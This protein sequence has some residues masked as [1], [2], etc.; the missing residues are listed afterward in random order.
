[1]LL[2]AV[3]DLKPSFVVA[4]FDMKGPTFRYEQYADYKA[5]R[6]RAPDELYEQIPRVKALCLALGIEI[7]ELQGFEADDIIA[8]LS[9]KI[10]ANPDNEV[11]VLTGDLDTL[12]LVNDRVRVYAPQNGFNKT[13]TYDSSAVIKR[14]GLKPEQMLDFRALKGD[15]SDNIPG[16]AGIGEKTASELIATYDT[17]ENLYKHLEDIKPRTMKLLVEGKDSAKQSRELAELVYDLPVEIKDLENKFGTYDI[18]EVLELFRELGF[19]SLI[20]KL[21]RDLGSQSADKTQA[22]M[23]QKPSAT[24]HLVDNLS[25]LKVLAKK[26][27]LQKLVAIDLETRNLD[28]DILG[29][30][31]AFDSDQSFYVSTDKDGIAIGQALGILKSFLEN[32]KIKKTGH[33]IKYDYK[34]LAKAGVILEGIAFDSMLAS[35]LL[36]P[37]QNS[38][39]LDQV[40]FVELGQR[41]LD[42]LKLSGQKKLD[43]EAIPTKLLKDYACQDAHLTYELYGKLRAKTNSPEY[44]YAQKLLDDI[45]LA[46]IPVLAD[47]ETAGIRLD[48]KMLE[49]LSL[50]TAKELETLTKQILDAA[51]QEFNIN[52]PA[53]LQEILFGKLGL[54]DKDIRKTKT[55]YSTAASELEKLHDAHPI[56]RYVLEYRE[57]SKLKNTYLDALPKLVDRGSRLHTSFNQTVAGT[58]RLSSTDPNLQNIPI[59]TERGAKIRKAFVS[60]PGMKLVSLDYSQIELRVAAAISDDPVMREAFKSGEDIH[61][62]TASKIFKIPLDEVSASQRRMAKTVNFGVLYGMNFFGLSWRLGISRPEAK[63]FID[64]YFENFGSIKQYMNRI[65]EGLKS[66][67]YVETMLGRRRYLPDIHASIP[68]VR[69]GAARAAINTPIQGTAADIMKIAMIKVHTYLQK[70]SSRIVLQ[71]HDELLLEVPDKDV[72]VIVRDTRKIMES[73]YKLDDIELVVDARSGDNWDEMIEIK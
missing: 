52:S 57:L 46:L 51:G 26:L 62:A 24:A 67:G 30:A 70:T 35:Y 3:K 50:E 63:Q 4:A 11:Y 44:A 42:L 53:Q 72:A 54:P 2:K 16:V 55:G 59:R 58:G 40:S 15:P 49:R 71:I 61:T 39:S 68:A 14:F 20:D 27:S 22:Q 73:A 1:M 25:D 29:I 66:T 65:I 48:S 43:F 36:N 38:H 69:S 8:T 9:K 5:K 64:E 56:V 17:L 28:G 60:E 21:P 13:I 6:V 18:N 7:F 41:K 23:V 33:G 47:I 19:R 34:A 10:T 45:E 12:Q 32:P 37:D 31:L